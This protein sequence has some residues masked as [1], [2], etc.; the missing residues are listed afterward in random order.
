MKQAHGGT[1]IKHTVNLA[2][3][4][5]GHIHALKQTDSAE[6][7]APPHKQLPVPQTG[8]AAK[9]AADRLLQHS[10]GTQDAKAAHRLVRRC[11][12]S[13]SPVKSATI[14]SPN[15][16]APSITNRFSRAFIFTHFRINGK[17]I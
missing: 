4:Q 8:R 12:E 1:G 15:A 6:K 17:E 9:S 13:Y 5:R 14:L 7:D 11:V 10:I 16:G 3:K 2:A